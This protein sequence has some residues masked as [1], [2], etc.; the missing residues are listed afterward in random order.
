MRT[1]RGAIARLRGWITEPMLV[2]FAVFGSVPFWINQ[3]GLYPYLGVEV[4]VFCIFALGFNV[5]FGHTGLPSFGHGAFFGIGAYA[6]GL[7]QFH[8]V[9]NLWIGLLA[10]TLVAAVFG[11]AVACF[12]SHRRGIYFALM[13]IAFSQLFF[14]IASKWT[15]VT[16]GEDGLLNIR[17]LPADFGIVSFPLRTNPALYWFAFACFVGIAVLLWRLVNSPFGR[18]LQAIKQ[19]EERVAFLGYNVWL[20]KWLSFALSCAVA[21]FAG[22]IFAMGQGGAFVQV[23]S[24]QWSGVIVLMVLIGGGLVSFWG[25][26]IG[27][28]IYFIARDLLGAYTET[29]LLW[30]GLM[31]MLMVMF[32]P[33]GAA[34]LW[35]DLR[36]RTTAVRARAPA[37]SFRTGGPVGT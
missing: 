27:T 33:E 7:T 18:V 35:A 5:L 23:M 26:V 1:A 37:A 2:A 22:G 16:G 3:V 13:T 28:V 34:G 21:G 32:K 19:N 6:M 30:F 12:I 24:L 17:R 10:A 8:L 11:A 14:F 15:S 25:P 20:Y 9:A 36:R 4:L 31:F 29:W